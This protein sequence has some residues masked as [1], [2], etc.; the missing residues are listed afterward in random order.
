MCVSEREAYEGWADE[1]RER[2]RERGAS[3][4]R[5][6]A[7][8]VA[9]ESVLERVREKERRNGREQEKKETYMDR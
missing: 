3:K 1:E 2:E 9:F 8:R 5:F 4:W 7:P 6:L